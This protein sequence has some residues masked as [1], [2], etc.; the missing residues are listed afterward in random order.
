MKISLRNRLGTND[1][2]KG[3]Y[4]ASGLLLSRALGQLVWMALLARI[5][6]PS[7][8]GLL[9]GV[10]ALGAVI[11][12]VSG[13]GIGTVL[14]RDVSRERACFD[15]IWWVAVLGTAVTGACL[16]LAFTSLGPLLLPKQGEKWLFAA[17]GTSELLCLPLVLLASQSFQAFDRIGWSGL[18]LWLPTLGNLAALACFLCFSRERSLSGYLPY[19]AAGSITTAASALIA[20]FI[21]LKPR[22]TSPPVNCKRVLSGVSFVA[23]RLAEHSLTSLDK[24]LVLKLIDSQAAGIYTAA[25]RLISMATLPIISLNMAAL[26]R[27]FRSG[28]SGAA[29]DTRH[30]AAQLTMM[31]AIY[32]V[33]AAL[34]ILVASD[35][36]PMLLGTGFQEATK[37]AKWLAL[38]P[39]LQGF[40]VIG[41]NILVSHDAPRLRLMMQV[42]SIITMLALALTLL[43]RFGM[44]GAIATLLATQLVSS[45]LVWL[46]VLQVLRKQNPPTDHA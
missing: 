36:L 26:P 37:V 29:P 35:L 22:W 20:V 10:T 18:L 34:A 25:Y 16:L 40:Y 8:Y 11:G 5:I 7:G 13:V 38:A 32:G 19:H 12:T 17:L 23:V 9:S 1:L 46:G 14:L 3:A 42:F 39:L 6:G 28:A 27:L 21:T 33:A 45:A 4:L 30:L 41:A 43:P 44:A 2:T 15:D 31:A 24:I